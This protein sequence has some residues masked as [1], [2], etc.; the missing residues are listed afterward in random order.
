M[1][2]PDQLQISDSKSV[3]GEG[4]PRLYLLNNYGLTAPPEEAYLFSNFTISL[5]GI[6]L[7]V[8]QTDLTGAW[9]GTWWGVVCG[10]VGFDWRC[11]DILDF[12]DQPNWSAVSNFTEW[13]SVDLIKSNAQ[14][15]NLR[16]TATKLDIWFS[17]KKIKRYGLDMV[18]K[19]K[20]STRNTA[21]ERTEQK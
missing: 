20:Q 7:M 10:H 9:G 11:V 17:I 1:F 2:V 12:I 15:I 8:K 18:D 14:T 19:N 13:A 3:S 21:N 6:S 16:K 5:S 4:G